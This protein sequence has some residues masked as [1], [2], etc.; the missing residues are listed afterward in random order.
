MKYAY[1]VILCGCLSVLPMRLCAVL[2]EDFFALKEE[3]D[4]LNAQRERLKKIKEE[5][6]R[7]E[8]REIIS[9]LLPVE[10]AC[11][12]KLQEVLPYIQ[13]IKDAL[14]EHCE[15]VASCS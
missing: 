5:T 3:L 15:D 2:S 4:V 14:D 9:K 11:S 6:P 12:K 8:R 13:D 10:A 1:L 7:G